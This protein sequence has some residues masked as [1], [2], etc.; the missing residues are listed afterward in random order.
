MA[1]ITPDEYRIVEEFRK[2][3]NARRAAISAG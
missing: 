2:E 1:R 3:Q